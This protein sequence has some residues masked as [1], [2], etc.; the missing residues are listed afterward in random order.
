MTATTTDNSDNLIPTRQVCQRYSVNERTIERW[1]KAAHVGFPEPVLINKRRYY[2][3]AELIV[4]ERQRYSE[5]KIRA[6][7]RAA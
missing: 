7:A 2:R 3:E 6:A 1:F 4:W 5:A